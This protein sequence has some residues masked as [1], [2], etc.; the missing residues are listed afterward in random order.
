MTT[1]VTFVWFAFVWLILCVVFQSCSGEVN[2]G[3]KNEISHKNEKNEEVHQPGDRK[4]RKYNFGSL[5]K[6]LHIESKEQGDEERGAESNDQK[7][8]N[9]NEGEAAVSTAKTNAGQ[10]KLS[11]QDAYATCIGMIEKEFKGEADAK[12]K[13]QLENVCTKKREQDEAEKA[14]LEA[15]DVKSKLNEKAPLKLRTHDGGMDND[16]TEHDS[17]RYII[18]QLG[19]STKLDVP[20]DVL[21]ESLSEVKNCVRDYTQKCPLNW[22]VTDT[23]EMLCVAPESYIGPCAKQIKND[24]DADEKVLMEKKCSI[25]WKCDYKCIQDFED[26]VCPIDWVMQKEDQYGYCVSPEGYT[27]KC[28]RKIK[29]STMTSKEK[30]IY[31]N[32]CDL[33]WPCKKNCTH[34]Y[35]VLCPSGWIEGAD[36]YCLATSSY[37]G[38]CEKKIYLKHLDEVMKQTYEHKCQFN[39]PCVHSCE[40]NYNDVCPNLWIPV[41][42]KECTPSENYNGRCKHNYIF[43]GKITEEEK[44]NFEKMCHVS[45]P[46]VKDC[47]RDYSFN[48]P[49]GWKETLSFCLAPTSYRYS[50][51]KMMKNNMTEREKIQISAKC[52]VFWPCS[53]YEVILKN[54]LH[55]NISSA[56]YMS[57]VNGPVNDAT[58]EVVQQSG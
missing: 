49:I 4:I 44:K 21:K 29:F 42:E 30:V 33:R 6:K 58:G 38:N 55:S 50:C 17:K 40:K 54:L 2:A 26:S 52:L 12:I 56:D 47:K 28:T 14:A 8:D 19:L 16:S 3:D 24:L 39:Y 53:N 5:K 27:G 31:S 23:N 43:K 11:P 1:R 22:Q 51:E 7:E 35:S 34:D 10:E 25:F 45:Y 48:C 13:E 9:Q 36:G 32:L 46:C 15:N 20:L 57:V 18:S 37:T 41:N